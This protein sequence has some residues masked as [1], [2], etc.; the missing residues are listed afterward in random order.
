[1]LLMLRQFHK[2]QIQAS[3]PKT[4]RSARHRHRPG[5]GDYDDYDYAGD[6]A[7]FQYRNIYTTAG[8]QWRQVSLGL[9]LSPRRTRA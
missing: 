5:Y 9:Q 8:W 4:I 7:C 3:S 6:S 1:M 2:P